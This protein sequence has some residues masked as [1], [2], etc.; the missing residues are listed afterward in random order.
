MRC[1]DGLDVVWERPERCMKFVAFGLLRDVVR[2]SHPDDLDALDA[3]FLIYVLSLQT[4]RSLYQ[5]CRS[6]QNIP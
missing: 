3:D 5:P 4:A 2:I 1:L 6:I